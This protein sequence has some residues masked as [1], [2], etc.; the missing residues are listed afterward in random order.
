MRRILLVLSVALVMAAMMLTNV[1]PAFAGSSDHNKD[2]TPGYS[3]WWQDK[4]T[5]TDKETDGCDRDG[6]KG[7]KSG[8]DC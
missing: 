2:G 6:S 8:T 1:T 7:Y 5:G 4:N 3:K